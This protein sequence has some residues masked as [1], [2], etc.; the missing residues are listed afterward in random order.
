MVHCFVGTAAYAASYKQEV[1]K[2]SW[3]PFQNTSD[4][5]NAQYDHALQKLQPA[6][7]RIADVSVVEITVTA[8]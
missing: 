3:L 4:R 1:Q 8:G 6:K 7:K 2:Y 5:Y